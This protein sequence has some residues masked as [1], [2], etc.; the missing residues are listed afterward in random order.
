MEIQYADQMGFSTVTRILPA[1]FLAASPTFLTSWQA[2]LS[3]F[4]AAFIARE[5]RWDRV[6]CGLAVGPGHGGFRSLASSSVAGLGVP[7]YS[8]PS[9]H[10]AAAFLPLDRGCSNKGA[11]RKGPRHG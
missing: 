2:F 10:T 11:S 8:R 1:E 4:V 3:A 6:G 9:R 7:A 5:Y